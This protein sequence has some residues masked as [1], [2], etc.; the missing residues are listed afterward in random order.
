MTKSRSTRVTPKSPTDTSWP[1]PMFGPIAV[2]R[3]SRQPASIGSVS[4][5]DTQITLQSRALH[6]M[7]DLRD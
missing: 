1:K 2:P 5:I 4:T 6:R 3:R 7:R